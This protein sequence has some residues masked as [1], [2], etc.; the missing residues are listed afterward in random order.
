[1]SST[2][3]AD[4]GLADYS[5]GVDEAER[6]RLVAQCE[7][8]RGEAARLIDRIGV[9]AGW[10]ALDLGCGPLGVLDIL[11]DRVGPAGRVTGADREPMFLA[12]ATRSMRERGLDAVISCR[13]TPPAPG[14]PPAR[15][16]SC[17]SASS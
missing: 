14:S 16:T 10:R 11:A 3:H 17:T 8:H 7:I 1:M 9:G 2:L 4:A 5:L 6:A 15:S 12:M 13:P